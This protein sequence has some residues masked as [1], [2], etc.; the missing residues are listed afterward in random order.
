MKRTII[1]SA[2]ALMFLFAGCGDDDDGN[3]TGPTVSIP[4]TPTGLSVTTAGLTSLTLS[5]GISDGATEY[6]L[7]RSDALDGVYSEVYS[8]AAAGFV[9]N[10]LPYG[11][12]YYYE[13]TAENSAGESEPSAPVNEMTLVPDG[14]VVTGSPAGSVDYTYSYY[15]QANGYPYYRS[16]PIGLNII[17]AASGPQA[18]LWIFNDQIEGINLYYNPTAAD[19]PP[20]T[21]WRAVYGGATTA[22]SVDPF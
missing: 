8:G 17:V 19:Y 4:D 21:G 1:F 3:G 22:I 11:T 20:R 5:W 6:K 2:I 18:G 15:A 16:N 10:G 12:R 9:D 14:F 7:Y 13:V